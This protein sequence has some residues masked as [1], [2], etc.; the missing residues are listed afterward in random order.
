MPGMV[1]ISTKIGSFRVSDTLTENAKQAIIDYIDEAERPQIVFKEFI[2][3]NDQPTWEV[4]VRFDL[5][6]SPNLNSAIGHK[7][8][9]GEIIPCPHAQVNSALKHGGKLKYAVARD[10]NPDGMSIKKEIRV[11]DQIKGTFEMKKVNYDNQKVEND[12]VKALSSLEI[13]CACSQKIMPYTVREWI[14]V[15]LTKKELEVPTNTGRLI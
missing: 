7:K 11:K 4:E 14:T 3:V 15:Q 10:R 8:R 6:A 13:V 5:A 9:T 12:V 1:V 2:Y